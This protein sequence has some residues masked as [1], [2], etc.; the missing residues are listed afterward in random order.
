MVLCNVCSENMEV[1]FHG[2]TRASLLRNSLLFGK[3]FRS[4]LAGRGDELGLEWSPHVR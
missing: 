4:E 3:C 1:K 2:E